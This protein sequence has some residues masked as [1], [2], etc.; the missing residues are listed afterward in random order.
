MTGSIVNR[1]K[2][3]PQWFALCDLVFH[4]VDFNNP[5]SVHTHWK[6]LEKFSQSVSGQVL[7]YHTPF[8]ANAPLPLVEHGKTYYL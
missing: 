3:L 5:N 6:S 8:L 2:L 7:G 4:E 1:E